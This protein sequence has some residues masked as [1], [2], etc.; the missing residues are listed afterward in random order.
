MSST[1]LHRR[2][3]H[4]DRH[5]GG[6]GTVGRSR[7]GHPHRTP[8]GLGVFM[9]TQYLDVLSGDADPAPQPSLWVASQV[10][11]VNADPIDAA[12]ASR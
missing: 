3:L 8:T 10:L 1:R 2:P 9:D 11:S 5:C 6:T 7:T 4:R 12:R